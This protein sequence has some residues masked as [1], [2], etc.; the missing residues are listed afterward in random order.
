[1][2]ASD[3]HLNAL[4]KAL[5]DPTRRRIIDELSR[6]DRQSLFEIHTRVLQEYGVDL[7]RQAFS[8]HLSA[9][10]AAGVLTI[11]WQGTTKLHSLNTKPLAELRSGWLARF[12]ENE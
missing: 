3:D 5:G 2:T 8:R 12:G 10:E 6:R 7:T 4:F 11:E 9:L 1:M